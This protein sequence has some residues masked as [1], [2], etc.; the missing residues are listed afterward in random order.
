[1]QSHIE[2]SAPTS[3]EKD[4]TSISAEYDCI[5]GLGNPVYGAVNPG[6]SHRSYVEN[7]S[8]LSFTGQGGILYWFLFSKLDKSS[9][10]KRFLG[11]EKPTWKRLPRLSVIFI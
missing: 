8:N 10:A 9:M 2:K 7:H 4:R 6:D 5:F 11:I 3:T 1:M